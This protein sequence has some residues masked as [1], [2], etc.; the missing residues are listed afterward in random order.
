METTIHLKTEANGREG[1]KTC[2]EGNKFVLLSLEVCLLY[3]IAVFSLN[4]S[5]RE[6]FY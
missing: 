4:Y 5:G 2:K 1:L 6:F 3:N